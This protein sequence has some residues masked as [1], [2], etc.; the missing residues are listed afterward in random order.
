MGDISFSLKAAIMSC[1]S[2]RVIH[3]SGQ[4]SA[5]CPDLLRLVPK[6]SM[7]EWNSCP[8]SSPWEALA[9]F[10]V[11][12]L[13]GSTSFKNPSTASFSHSLL[14]SLAPTYIPTTGSS[15]SSLPNSFGRFLWLPFFFFFFAQ[16]S[17][18]VNSFYYWVRQYSVS[19]TMWVISDSLL[20]EIIY[21]KPLAQYLVH[22]VGIP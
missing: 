20:G 17:T 16:W 11:K 8:F 22:M 2:C 9:L 14:S 5:I 12:D 13:H 19:M 4:T 6:S 10:R 18:T 15:I 7:S 1:H 3:Q 21:I